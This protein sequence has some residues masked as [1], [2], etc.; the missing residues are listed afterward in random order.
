MP[1]HHPAL[2]PAEI[3]FEPDV[4]KAWSEA[5]ITPPVVLHRPPMKFTSA[6]PS[7]HLPVEKGTSVAFILAVAS[8][9]SVESVTVPD[10]N[11]VKSGR[12]HGDLVANLSSWRFVPAK[13]ETGNAIPSEAT[14]TIRFDK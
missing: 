9:G 2:P 12:L 11:G 13:D 4:E 6:Y 14:I 10:W 3:I 5:K 8:D 1:V 7:G